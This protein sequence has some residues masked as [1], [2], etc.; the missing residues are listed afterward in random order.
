MK[1]LIASD[2]HGSAYYCEKLIDQFHRHCADKLIILGDVLYHGPRNALPL[3]YEPKK[4]AEMLNKISDKIICIKGNCDCEV[5]QMMLDFPIMADFAI[6]PC[7]NR[8]IFMTHGHKYGAEVIEKYYRDMA[9]YKAAMERGDKTAV[10]PAPIPA[11]SVGDVLLQGHTHQSACYEMA[12]GVVNINPGSV[13]IAKNGDTCGYMTFEDN[14]FTRYNLDGVEQA[15]YEINHG[16]T[17]KSEGDEEE[18]QLS[19]DSAEA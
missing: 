15:K 13:S 3:G 8:T 11:I 19:F 12:C 1:Y 7:G 16:A 6:M 9:E 17:A 5:D 10:R 2:I 4:V 18:E 14:I